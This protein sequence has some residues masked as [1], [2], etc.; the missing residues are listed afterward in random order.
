[1]IKDCFTQ[2]YSPEESPDFVDSS[3]AGELSP[4]ETVCVTIPTILLRMY[5]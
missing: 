2:F 4:I 5:S 1:M 3:S